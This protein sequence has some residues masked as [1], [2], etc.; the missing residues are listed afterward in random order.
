M[1]QLTMIH[2]PSSISTP[3]R[4]LFLSTLSSPTRTRHSSPHHTIHNH[5]TQ[6]RTAI[7]IPTAFPTMSIFTRLEGHFKPAASAVTC[8]PTI[9]QPTCAAT[10]M[11]L[12][13]SAMPY[14]LA[15]FIALA[16]LLLI[17]LRTPL[18]RA[19]KSSS[20]AAILLTRKDA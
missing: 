19:S 5:T 7:N 13:D 12:I 6:Q 16:I 4:P 14:A 3:T 9:E 18:A 20:P 15:V 1:S 17:N 10:M 11:G 8:S 2:I